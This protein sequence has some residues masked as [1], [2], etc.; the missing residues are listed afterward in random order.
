MNLFQQIGE[1]RHDSVPVQIGRS[2]GQN[3]SGFATA[4][5]FLMVLTVRR[6]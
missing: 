4:F 6:L 3:G 1:V 2:L 5:V